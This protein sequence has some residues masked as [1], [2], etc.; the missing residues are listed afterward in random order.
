M[1]LAFTVAAPVLADRVKTVVG[2]FAATGSSQTTSFIAS[3][4]TH[5]RLY[6]FPVGTIATCTVK[7][8]KS[9]DGSS[10]SDLVAATGCT[11]AGA[12]AVTAA[13]TNYVRFTVT[14]LTGGGTL[15]VVD[16][17]YNA[18]PSSVAGSGLTDAQLRA[19]PV[20]VSGTIACSNCGGS[21]SVLM[22]DNTANPTIPQM[23]TFG[24]LYDGATWDRMLGDST[25]G[26]WVNLKASVPIAVTGTFWQA[27]QPV[28]GTFW[29]GTQPVSGTF[30]QATQP[31]SGTVTTT[32][33]AN[34]S[35]NIAQMNGATVSMNTG[36]RDAGTQRVTIATNDAV[37]VTGTFWP[38]TQPVSGTVTANAGTGTLA[39]SAAS[40]PL[41]TGAATEATLVKLPIARG[42]A[43]G[44]NAGPLIQG[45]VTVLAPTYTA[46]TINPLSLTTWGAM[47]TD[48]SGTTQ[49]VSAT[50]WQAT[51]PVSIATMPSTPVTGTVTA[52]AGAN[53]NTSALALD[54]TLT[55]GTQKTQIVDPVA[56]SVATVSAAGAIRVDG[57]A[58]TQPVSGTFWQA[59]QPVSIATMP[60]TP[61]TGTFWQATQPVSGTVTA[62]AGTNLNTSALALDA[63]LTGGT[64]RAKVTDGTNNAAV[65][66]ASTAAVATDPAL[67]VAVSP[68]NT[69]P[70]NVSQ[71]AGATTATGFG[72]SGAGTQRVVPAQ[73]ATYGATLT[74]R[75]A[76]A[77][78]I[79]RFFSICGSATKT[80]RIQNLTVSGTIATTAKN[81]DVLAIKTSTATLGGTRTTMARTPFDSNSAAA[82]VAEPV[83]CTVLCTGGGVLGVIAARQGYF[84][85]APALDSP[86]VFDWSN[87]TDSEAP[88]LRGTAQCLEANFGTTTTNVPTLLVSVVWTEK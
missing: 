41:P 34:A 52:D 44:T 76:T 20:P 36:V 82:T 3:T 28:S 71:I 61:V 37:P 33:P 47:R 35:T 6:Y 85:I 79:N 86:A 14:V 1:L 11:A 13:Q 59:T 55:N 81:V 48:S 57:S 45:S 87:R 43:L 62:N 4:A 80:V 72:V 27:T 23:A 50:F 19:T 65:K 7:L 73:E 78:G 53:L 70:V 21:A 54:A 38:G 22:A 56:G 68:N 31:V 83:F 39:V 74:A 69:I 24:M 10:W 64:Q 77:A 17:A 9:Q 16:E 46:G 26:L 15:T 30:W 8:E 2:S 75:T 18:D 88:V 51:Q 25:N 49:P 29:P 58:I 63:T 84:P 66:A 42:A 60:T 12:S 5:H 67:V 40:L 32:P